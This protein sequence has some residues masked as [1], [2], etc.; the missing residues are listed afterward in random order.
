M[1]DDCIE[2][3]ME[4]TKN[5]LSSIKVSKF[6]NG[7]KYNERHLRSVKSYQNSSPMAIS[8]IGYV[9]HYYVLAT[10]PN[11]DYPWEEGHCFLHAPHNTYV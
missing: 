1:N 5:K 10:P 3:Q 4:S 2:K 11:K 6:L 7:T 8:H 9:F